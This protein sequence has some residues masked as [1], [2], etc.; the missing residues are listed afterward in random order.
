VFGGHLEA[1]EKKVFFPCHSPLRKEH[2]FE[3][4]EEKI[5]TNDFLKI[6]RLRNLSNKRLQ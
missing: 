6:N 2:S 3:A 1:R 4:S 5:W